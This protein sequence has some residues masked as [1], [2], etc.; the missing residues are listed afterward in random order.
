MASLAANPTLPN[1][2]LICGI[3]E[4][5]YDDNTHQAKFLTCHHTYCSECLSKLVNGQV[6][7]VI[8]PCPSCR[9]DTR[10]PENGVEG[11]QTNFYITRLQ[12]CSQNK[13]PSTAAANSH[14]CHKQNVQPIS[15]LCLTCGKS[16]CRD[17]T[18]VDHTAKNG[19]TVISISKLGNEYLDELNVS[20]KSLNQN[21]RNLKLIKSER[22]LLTVAKETAEKDIEKFIKLAHE[23][24]EQHRTDLMNRLL[25]Q[26]KT[27]QNTLLDKQKTIR[28][29]V[30]MLKNSIIEAKNGTKFTDQRGLQPILESLKQLNKKSISSSLDLGENYLA[31]DSNEGLD[32]LNQCLC[33]P[34]KISTKGFLPITIAF[35]GTEAKVGLKATLTVDV[36]DHQGHTVPLSSGALSVHITDPMD[37]K[38]DTF[39]NTVGSKCT[40]TFTP[41]ISG[42]HKI[43]GLF[44]GQ[45]LISEQTHISVSSNNPVLK[46]GDYGWDHGKFKRPVDIAIDNRNNCLYV[47][48]SPN[49]PI[50]KFTTDGKFLSQ[51][52]TA[53]PDHRYMAVPD[54]RCTTYDIALDL[55][56]GLMFTAAG[57]NTLVFNLEGELQYTL[58]HPWEAFSIAV[59][60]QGDL[61]M[62]SK[63][64]QCVF[65]V[66]KEG[67]FLSSMAHVKD[68]G[69]IAIDED[70][71]IIVPSEADNCIYIL[72]P[73]GTVRHKFGSPGTGKGQLKGPRGVASDG[74]YILVSEIDNNRVQ[75]FNNDGTFVSMIDSSAHPL[76]H[77]CGLAVTTDGYVYVVDKDNRCI[78]KFQYKNMS[79]I[80]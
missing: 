54:Q 30:K 43:S 20:C 12:E 31:F 49:K 77:P 3:C 42:L 35:R 9:S 46:F 4:E 57:K 23:Q 44:L 11:L 59:D 75:V 41:Q 47:V 10:L 33:H 78:K 24:I 36:C 60:Q 56:K 68:P 37:T 79:W 5:P 32:P 21:S 53:V 70:N 72:N 6:N 39:L 73:D 62:S 76:E 19:H 7:P 65:K 16:I 80:K 27:K 13:E 48:D 29:A 67:N 18:I 45:E 71:S 61:I 50:Q 51:F 52:S 28:K 34:G 15:H 22:T 64:R 8:I 25:Q 66:D 58:R 26:F 14:D 2:L 38:L 1:E 63:E 17:C 55:N 74:E 69:Y 40:V